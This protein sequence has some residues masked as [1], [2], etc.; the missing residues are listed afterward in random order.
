[1]INSSELFGLSEFL[2]ISNFVDL[3]GLH[4]STEIDLKGLKSERKGWYL[5]L[6]AEDSLFK[7]IGG[8]SNPFTSKENYETPRFTRSKKDFL[9]TVIAIIKSV[10]FDADVTKLENLIRITDT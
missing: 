7:N 1:M 2:D 9:N 4:G 6:G 5:E 10:D 3:S 8:I